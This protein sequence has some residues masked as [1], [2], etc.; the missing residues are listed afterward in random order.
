MASF[1]YDNGAFRGKRKIWGGRARVRSMLYMA[2]LAAT[3]SNSVMRAS[4]KRPCA[5]GKPKK[6]ALATFVGK[7][8]RTE[9]LG[10]CPRL[11]AVRII[12]A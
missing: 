10:D 7:V 2:N 3:R 5:L 11:K 6:V 12:E 1:N 8:T 4:H 9:K